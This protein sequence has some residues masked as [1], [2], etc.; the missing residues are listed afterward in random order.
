MVNTQGP[1][2]KTQIQSD[3]KEMNGRSIQFDFWITHLEHGVVIV[4]EVR[5]LQPSLLGSWQVQYR[6]GTQLFFVGY[7]AKFAKNSEARRC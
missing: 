6:P 5:P 1:K 4:A 3:N 7:Y 2:F